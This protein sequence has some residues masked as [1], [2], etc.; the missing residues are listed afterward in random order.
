MTFGTGNIGNIVTN[1]CDWILKVYFQQ[2]LKPILRKSEL[3]FGLTKQLRP[4]FEPLKKKNRSDIWPRYDHFFLN[5]TKM[6]CLFIYTQM[7]YIIHSLYYI[8]V[9]KCKSS[10]YIYLFNKVLIHFI[11]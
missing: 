10:N 4:N 8:F 9:R 6:I 2:T 3:F 11:S 1:T 7:T 5:L